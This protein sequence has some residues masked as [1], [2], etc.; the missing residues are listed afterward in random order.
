MATGVTKRHSKGCPGRD[1]GRCNCRAGW[2]ASVYSKRDKRKIR[3]TF[4]RGRSRG[5]PTPSQRSHAV[6]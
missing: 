6:A 5:E 1:G 3:R 4:D 2:E